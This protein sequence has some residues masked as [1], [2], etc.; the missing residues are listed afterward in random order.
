M[1]VTID[2]TNP[3]LRRQIGR[4]RQTR[5]TV[6]LSVDGFGTMP[7]FCGRRLSAVLPLMTDSPRVEAVEEE[8]GLSPRRVSLW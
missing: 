1:A 7:A 8:R 4:S 6:F 5:C 3:H 2:D